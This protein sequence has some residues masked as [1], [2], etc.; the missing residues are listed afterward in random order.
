MNSLSLEN[1]TSQVAIA[2]KWLTDATS[3]ILLVGGRS[4]TGKHTFVRRFASICNLVIF[5]SDAKN[6]DFCLHHCDRAL[7]IF[8]RPSKINSVIDLLKEHRHAR[9]AVI[10]DDIVSFKTLSGATIIEFE[11][12]TDS[13]IRSMLKEKSIKFT[14]FFFKEFTKLVQKDYRRLMVLIETLPKGRRLKK[15]DCI[16]L[17]ESW[18]QKNEQQTLYSICN[19]IMTRRLPYKQCLQHYRSERSLLPLTLHENIIS[20]I[21]FPTIIDK[22]VAKMYRCLS[23]G[24]SIDYFIYSNN[25][26]MLE[27]IYTA[28]TIY[29]LNSQCKGTICPDYKKLNFTRLLNKTSLKYVYFISYKKYVPKRRLVYFDRD[30]VRHSAQMAKADHH[31]R[32]E[33]NAANKR[34]TAFLQKEKWVIKDI[35]KIL[36]L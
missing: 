17:T 9:A 22:H 20:Y 26:W 2:T 23:R 30:L 6:L 3:R 7:V 29:G 15:E 16:K 5:K 24:D 35:N 33:D 13:V 18:V 32:L 31:R 10:V 21:K 34:I 1:I 25:E 12:P 4:G 19:D 36:K 11:G 28:V 8:N 27:A 14:G